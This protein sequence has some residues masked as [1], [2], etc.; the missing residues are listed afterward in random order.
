MVYSTCSVSIEENEGVVN[1]IL[2]SGRDVKLVPFAPDIG[3]PGHTAIGQW[4]F[5]DCMKLTRRF[6]PHRHDMDGFFVAKFRKLS[7]KV[8]R[9]TKNVSKYNKFV[10]SADADWS[11]VVAK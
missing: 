6:W 5:P 4:R 9:K 10:K 7:N 11:E 8:V 1:S 2:N 3:S